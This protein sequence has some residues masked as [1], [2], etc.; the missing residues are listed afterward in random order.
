MAKT[1]RRSGNYLVVYVDGAKMGSYRISD[2][3]FAG[4]TKYWG[5]LKKELKRRIRK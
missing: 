4:A 3:K 5:D 1:F 2:G